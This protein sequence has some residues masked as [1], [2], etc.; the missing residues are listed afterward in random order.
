V[1]LGV[2]GGVA[3]WDPTW[4]SSASK[5][6]NCVKSWLGWEYKEGIWEDTMCATGAM[7]AMGAGDRGDAVAIR[8]E[9]DEG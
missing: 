8:D 9:G 1:R 4:D 6:I 3:T 7:G 5:S 2:G